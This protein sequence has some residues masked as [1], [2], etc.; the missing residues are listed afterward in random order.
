MYDLGDHR[1]GRRPPGGESGDTAELQKSPAF[2]S[3]I[4]ADPSISEVIHVGDIRSGRDFCTVAYDN[5]IASLWRQ[6]RKPV[7]YTPGDNEWS[8]C[9]KATSL[10]K[11]G[12]G[13]GFYSSGVLNYIGTSGL[14]TDPSMCVDYHCGNPIDNHA[15]VRRLFFSQPGQTL[16]SGTL[17]V[18]SQATA[19]DRHQFL[20]SHRRLVGA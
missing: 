10:A 9:H 19:Y 5:Q 1:S 13:G 3:T 17:N 12:E 15:K 7:V 20:E 11:P 8:D 2:I 18:V 16:G 6:F 4:N 14:T